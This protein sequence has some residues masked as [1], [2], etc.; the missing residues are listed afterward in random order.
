L[1]AWADELPRPTSILMISTDLTVALQQ[2]IDGYWLG[3]SKR[4][5]QVA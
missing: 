5:L 4:S 3:L 2:I 1:R